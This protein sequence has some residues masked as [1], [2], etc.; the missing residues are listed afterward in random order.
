M[1][2][3]RCPECK[4]RVPRGAE[5][6]PRCGAEVPTRPPKWHERTSVTLCVAGVLAIIALGFIH[7][8]VGVEGPYN[9]PFDIVRRESFG[10]REMLVDA[11]KIRT[12]PY[13]AAKTRYPLGCQ[14]LQLKGYL[15]SSPTFETRMVHE[16]REA[17]DRWYAEFEVATGRMQRPWHDR[18][19]EPAEAADAGTHNAAA[20]NSRGV[21][22]ARQGRYGAALSE[23][24]A[25]IKKN[26]ALAEAYHNRALVYVALGNLGQ[27]AS[28]FSQVIEIRPASVDACIG[29]GLIHVT[30]ER[31]DEAIADFTKAIEIDP[32][33]VEAYVRRGMIRYAKGENQEAWEDVHKLQSLGAPAPP[34]FLE[35]LRGESPEGTA[36]PSRR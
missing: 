26:P 23:F 12:L 36:S 1:G 35:A 27:A 8:I 18:L 20:Y 30:R 10:Y 24:S 6:C 28:D 17:M 9:V 3:S 2:R 4:K 19:Q 13:V 25:A 15:P 29:R 21:T 22:C 16:L 14:V 32:T 5:T 34:G 11:G 31:Y 33:C 7:V